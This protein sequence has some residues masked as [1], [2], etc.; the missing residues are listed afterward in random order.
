MTSGR[1]GRQ[2]HQLTITQVHSRKRILSEATDIQRGVGVKASLFFSWL[3]EKS[4]LE[5]RPY[6]ADLLSLPHNKM[7]QPAR[8]FPAT[9]RTPAHWMRRGFEVAILVTDISIFYLPSLS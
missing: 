6:G 2:I 5:L 7:T 9:G 3:D 1:T 8:S 4:L